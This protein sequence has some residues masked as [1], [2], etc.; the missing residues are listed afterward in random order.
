M[1]LKELEPVQRKIRKTT[2]RNARY[3][4][5]KKYVETYS[6]SSAAAYDPEER[7]FYNS[8]HTLII[9]KHNPKKKVGE[10]YV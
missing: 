7:V 3:M 9:S 1:V 5:P 10:H 2:I 6:S 4:W 8:L